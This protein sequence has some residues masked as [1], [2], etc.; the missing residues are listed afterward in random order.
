[1]REIINLKEIQN[2]EYEILK[3]FV[4]FCEK[5]NLKY[6]L[7]GGTLL[8]AI[9]HQGF[10]PWDDDIDIMMPRPDFNK[11]I[12]LLKEKN[13]N[14]ELKDLELASYELDKNYIY[15]I[16]KLYD[17]RTKIKFNDHIVN[18]PLGLWI[19][20][21]VL[22][23]VPNGQIS[24]KI[25]FKYQRVLTY[26]NVMSITKFG[27]K[28]KN[29]VLTYGQFL[30]YPIFII[31][32]LIGHKIFVGL[33]EKN[34]KTYSFENSKYVAVYTGRALEKEIMPKDEFMNL[35]KTKFENT[36]FYIPGNYDYY[37]TR[38]Y[39][40]YMKLPP[41]NQRETRHDMKIYWRDEER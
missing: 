15:P 21:F 13:I 34:A 2:L 9:R 6:C 25:K 31:A 35:K 32:R 39:G 36:E 4:K 33:L 26:L 41:E 24:R 10:I 38:L 29:R 16:T 28:R 22:D 1:M 8:G 17:K 12:N 18:Y 40:D 30:L 7:C 3:K 11:F 23:G 37:L 27:I 20:I 5:Y 14:E 19:D